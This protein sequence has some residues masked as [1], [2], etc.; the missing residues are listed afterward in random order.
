MKTLVIINELFED[1]T[2][3]Q[4]TTLAYI[5]SVL[6]KGHEVSIYNL[7]KADQ[8]FSDAENGQISVITLAPNME[9]SQHLI[10]QYQAINMD[11]VQLTILQNQ[12]SLSN[13]EKETLI[14]LH[15]LQPKKVSKITAK[16]ENEL[17]QASEGRL[18][19]EEAEFVIQR[20]E[21]MKAPFPP[22]GNQNFDE[23]LRVLQSTFPNFI[24][25]CPIGLGDKQTP[26]EIDRILAESEK[27]TISTPAADFRLLKTTEE[28]KEI[29]NKLAESIG[30]A[31]K[32]YRMFY[33]GRS[34]LGKVVI[35]PENSAQSLGVFAIEFDGNGLNLESLR[36]KSINELSNIQIYKI[37][38][39]L[40]PQQLR[41][42][43]E[44]LC[45]IQAFKASDY[46]L[47]EMN[48]RKINSFSPK[49][50]IQK[51]RELYNNNILVQPFLEGVKLGDVRMN[52][53]KN[54][55]GDFY[56]AGFTFRQSARSA[57]GEKFTTCLT[58]GSSIAQPVCCLTKAEQKNLMSNGQI[59]VNILNNELHQKY[60][61]STELGA[62]FLLVGDQ[63]NV[64][65][66]EINHTCPALI[67]IS[68]AMSEVQEEL[69]KTKE[70]QEE[71][72]E[73]KG[74]LGFISRAID[75]LIKIQQNRLKETEKIGQKGQI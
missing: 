37:R 2:L 67:P 4:S 12:P 56:V 65:L 21:P 22:A 46:Q 3:G 20:I 15:N 59:L 11:I 1:M 8:I 62:D 51:A 58:T 47:K 72:S 17:K 55:N 13:Q 66:G 40:Q 38:P 18:A 35:K 61:N 30:F 53:L 33:P 60:V 74:G 34:S 28:D 48:S 75:D 14:G 23:N 31:R 50:I 70:K 45:F 52:L 24:L 39:N 73:Y 71:I 69:F 6:Q 44:I 54:E 26:L 9:F 63:K 7:P 27:A 68:E 42:V 41:Q 29:R 19:L 5:A 16:F 57:G 36:E 10:Q 32:Q 49:E 43:V 64:R 25:N